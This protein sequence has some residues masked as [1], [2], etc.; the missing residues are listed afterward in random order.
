VPLSSPVAWSVA[1]VPLPLVVA[2]GD[3]SAV[4]LGVGVVE[5]V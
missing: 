1:A 3:G 4:G 5:P 2:L